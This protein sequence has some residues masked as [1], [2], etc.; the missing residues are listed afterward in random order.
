MTTLPSNI[1][2]SRQQVAT[3]PEGDPSFTGNYRDAAL[4]PGKNPGLAELL[5][6]IDAEVG[7]S[8]TAE[9]AALLKDKLQTHGK[10]NFSIT[11]EQGLKALE[12]ARNSNDPEYIAEA[13]HWGGV[14]LLEKAPNREAFNAYAREQYPLD[15]STEY[16]QELNTAAAQ[17]GPAFPGGWKQVAPQRY[18]VM[19][20]K[21]SQMF[22]VNPNL[23]V[24][25]MKNES[26]FDAGAQ[27]GVGAQGL[28]QVMPDTEEGIAR[29]FRKKG[30]PIPGDPIERNI[31]FGIY[32]LREM[33]D[34]FNGDIAATIR[35]YNAGPGNEQSGKSLTFSE[36]RNYL[37][38]VTQTLQSLR[39]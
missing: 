11:V 36:T 32:Y 12:I 7:K 14:A 37:A 39:G 26:G 15:Y 8:L 22:N 27:S 9:S 18:H 30:I 34:M 24:A 2:N 17:Y 25:I 33:S 29:S 31:A 1:D 10:E 23:V 20:E 13:L 19:I 16:R 38:K 28:M 4:Q 21:Y 3:V 6:R 35:A 5:K